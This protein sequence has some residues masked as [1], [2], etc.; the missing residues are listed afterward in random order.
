MNLKDTLEKL[1]DTAVFKHWRTAHPD[2]F[3]SY[4]LKILMEQNDDEWQI[5]FYNKASE[6][7]TTFIINSSETGI[8]EDEEVF[9]KPGTQIKEIDLHDAPLTHSEIMDIVAKHKTKEYPKEQPI[10]IITILQHYEDLGLVWNIT[11]ITASFNTLNL[12]VD[13]KTGKILS[14]KL[15]SILKLGKEIL[16]KHP[17]AS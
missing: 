10:K 16:G 17:S 13:A 8:R 12:K 7:V 14:E 5:G 3:M 15:E 2:D 4:A 9:K 1:R 6:H 11:Y